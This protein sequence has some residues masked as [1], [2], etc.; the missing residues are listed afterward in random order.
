MTNIL[1]L[2]IIYNYL[3]NSIQIFR[4][5]SYSIVEFLLQQQQQLQS[6]KKEK[7][8]NS[9]NA[10]V[11]SK[12]ISKLFELNQWFTFTALMKSKEEDF[13]RL[14]IL[15]PSRNKTK[16]MNIELFFPTNKQN[17]VP[18]SAAR[19]TS[20]KHQS[21]TVMPV[22][23]NYTAPREPI[24]LCH[25]LYGF[26]LRGPESLPALQLHYWSGVE[27]TLAKL[28]CKVIVTKVPQTGSI[29]ER[30]H[31]LHD[32]LQKTIIAGKKVNFVAHSML[33]SF[34]FICFQFNYALLN[35]VG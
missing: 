14:H 1:S 12:P 8:T 22:S 5:S 4:K 20:L 21:Q 31:A 9:K 27:E 24:V 35:R 30:S 23:S 25:G 29:W 6:K 18:A 34:F 15:Y 33:L 16:D 13:H 3:Q 10:T 19:V 32:I 26:D 11:H 28:G 2:Y 17:H 7:I